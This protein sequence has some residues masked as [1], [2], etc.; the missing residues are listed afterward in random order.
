MAGICSEHKGYKETCH[1]CNVTPD[2]L[3]GVT[4]EEWRKMGIAAQNT[5]IY[6]CNKCEFIY[7]KTVNSCPRCGVAR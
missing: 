3:L 6:T 4:K 7:Y 5:G 1:L 2:Q